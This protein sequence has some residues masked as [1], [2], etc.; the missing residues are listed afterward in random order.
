MSLITHFVNHRALVTGSLILL[1]GLSIYYLSSKG[2][3]FNDRDVSSAD[4][5]QS[6]QEKTEKSE[7]AN[8]EKQESVVADRSVEPIEEKTSKITAADIK[9][10]SVTIVEKGTVTEPEQVS[11][12]STEEAVII[13]DEP[14]T[15][16]TIVETTEKLQMDDSIVTHVQEEFVIVDKETMTA[17]EDGPV[18]STEKESTKEEATR[19]KTEEEVTSLSIAEVPTATITEPAADTQYAAS[20]ADENDIGT[21]EN[22]PVASIPTFRSYDDIPEFIPQQKQQPTRKR[23][24][25]SLTRIQ[26]IEQQ[27]QNHTPTVN[28]RCNHWPRCTNKHCKYWHPFKM[29][30]AGDSCY[31]GKKCMFVHPSD[32][33]EQPERKNSYHAQQQQQHQQRDQQEQQ[34]QPHQQQQQFF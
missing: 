13:K 12:I 24:K 10:E 33:L 27:R 30:R 17:V 19:I 2:K 5:N 8:E 16:T 29:C 25:K 26:L 3:E 22:E 31:Y 15:T 6:Q 20:S 21:P 11:V 34:Q 18:K 7:K 23:S 28:A 4:E 1:G 9:K 14:T 32:Y